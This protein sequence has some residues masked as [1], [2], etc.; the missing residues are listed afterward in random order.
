MVSR[1]AIDWDGMYPPYLFTPL[2]YILLSVVQ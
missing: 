1:E 2:L